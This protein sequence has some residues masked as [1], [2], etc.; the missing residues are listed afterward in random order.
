MGKTGRGTIVLR[1]A[2]VDVYRTGFTFTG[3]RLFTDVDPDRGVHLAGV[4][5]YW[6]LA[7]LVLFNASAGAA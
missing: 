1:K 5:S 2:G 6:Q 7:E 4:H 3:D